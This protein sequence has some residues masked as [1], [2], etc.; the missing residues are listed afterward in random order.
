MKKIFII[1]IIIASLI[2][3]FLLGVFDDTSVIIVEKGEKIYL[4]NIRPDKSDPNI[5]ACIPVAYTGDD[6]AGIIGTILSGRGRSSNH[7]YTPIVL[8]N[9]TYFQQFTLVRNHK[10]RSFTDKRLRYRRALCKKDGKFTIEQSIH[11]TTLDRFARSLTKYDSAW[12]LDMGTSSYGWY[13]KDGKL[14]HLGISTFWNKAKQ[15]NWIVIKKC[16]SSN[17]KDL[18]D[19]KS[20]YASLQNDSIFD[21]QKIMTKNLERAESVF[22][23][24]FSKPI[25]G[26]NVK[27]ILNYLQEYDSDN[28]I[29]FAI[30]IFSND[31][32]VSYNTHPWFVIPDSILSN[33]NNYKIN[34]LDYIIRKLP[35]YND[36][37]MGQFS[38][39]PFAFYDVD[40]D[41]QKE[42]LFRIIN[43][44]QRHRNTYVV[45]KYDSDAKD[46][47]AS[48]FTEYLDSL[49]VNNPK[50]V[51]YPSLDDM[52]EF[53]RENQEVILYESA[54]YIGNEKHYYKVTDKLPHLYM[55]ETYYF[56]YD[57][58]GKRETFKNGES[59]IE[60][61][62]N[63]QERL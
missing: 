9:N 54:G 29:G 15:S 3:L 5:I 32:L 6:R 35:Y 41:N 50:Y 40:F 34:S 36:N 37:Q 18:S 20:F 42:L 47:I 33:W 53:D 30:L 19:V 38:E 49:Y 60:Y 4:T 39:V 28:H 62:N 23:F 8:D 44:G 52:T 12:N 56:G 58:L 2:G 63:G 43:S 46:F 26:F 21:W 45:L 22:Y 27:G 55:I 59:I 14:H 7:S 57:S 17:H 25:N 1:S 24:Q 10:P 51:S 48:Q 61:F 31:T 13:K 16:T 11:P